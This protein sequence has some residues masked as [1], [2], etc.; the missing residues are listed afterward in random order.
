[1]AFHDSVIAISGAS[2]GIGLGVATHLAQLGARLS[3]ADV[4]L[5]G[6]LGKDGEITDLFRNCTT[7][8][9]DV[10]DAHSVDRWIVHTV[11]HFGKLDG[12]V[13]CAGV[14]LHNGPTSMTMFCPP[15][16]LKQARS[17][18]IGLP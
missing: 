16:E 7:T 3:L 15:V 10:R 14:W 5:T 13:N 2:S 1:M 18:G 11:E 12:A 6:L 4:N 9:V 8:T 17:S